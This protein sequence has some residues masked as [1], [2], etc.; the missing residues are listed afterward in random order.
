V[1][2]TVTF[3]RGPHPN[4]FDNLH[5]F[6]IIGQW[7]ASLTESTDEISFEIVQ[8]VKA[9]EVVEEKVTEVGTFKQS[10]HIMSTP[11]DPLL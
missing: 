6:V 4:N 5:N 11:T 7:P 1:G 10:S 3:T 8:V 9:V 2:H